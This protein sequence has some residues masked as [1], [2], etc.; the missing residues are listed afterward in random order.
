MIRA[1]R[2]A[3]FKA[4][5]MFARGDLAVEK[6]PDGSRSPITLGRVTE[7]VAAICDALGCP[8]IYATQLMESLM[9]KGRINRSESFDMSAAS[10]A[11]AAVMLNKGNGANEPL[12]VGE[13]HRAAR[14]FGRVSQMFETLMADGAANQDLSALLRAAQA[15]S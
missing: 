5:V 2:A 9:K 11:F 4:S 12:V 7:R 8:L 15:Y 13:F 14:K 3:G 1:V 10:A 6:I